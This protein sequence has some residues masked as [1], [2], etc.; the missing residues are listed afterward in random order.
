MER[1]L[2]DRNDGVDVL[3]LVKKEEVIEEISLVTIVDQKAN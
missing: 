1:L 2:N 3:W